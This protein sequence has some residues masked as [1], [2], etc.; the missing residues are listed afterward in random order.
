MK[1]AT[2]LSPW[3]AAA[4]VFALIALHIAGFELLAS[5]MAI[6]LI[7]F[8]YPQMYETRGRHL[9]VRMGLKWRE[10]QYDEMVQLQPLKN[11]AGYGGP[12]DLEIG[13]RSGQSVKLSPRDNQQFLSDLFR[14]APHL[15]S[16]TEDVSI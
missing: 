16:A 3:V 4:A 8:A 2:R 15:K 5:A 10:F 9:L 1:H 12:H 7:V 6:A 13:L 14:H 11:K